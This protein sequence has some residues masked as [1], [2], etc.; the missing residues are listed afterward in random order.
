[1]RVPIRFPKRSYHRHTKPGARPP[2]P[3]ELGESAS[4]MMLLVTGRNLFHEYSHE[5]FGYFL[6]FFLAF[7]VSVALYRRDRIL[8]CIR[9]PVYP[10]CAFPSWRMI[11]E[12]S[13]PSRVR[14]AAP[15][16]APLTAAGGSEQTFPSKRERRQRKGLELGLPGQLKDQSQSLPS[17]KNSI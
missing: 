16:G 13:S 5:K 2:L 9:K 3:P 12:P 1:M 7:G 11:S 14:C 8:P 4:A 17:K 15:G 6:E 10:A